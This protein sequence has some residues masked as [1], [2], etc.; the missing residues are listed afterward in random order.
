MEV[1]MSP[2]LQFWFRK[3][4]FAISLSSLF[5]LVHSQMQKGKPF[6]SGG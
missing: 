3:N 1:S 2:D 4:V 5:F 6:G